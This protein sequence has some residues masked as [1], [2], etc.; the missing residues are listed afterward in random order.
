MALHHLLIDGRTIQDRFPGIARYVYNLAEALAPL[1]AGEITLLTNPDLPNSRYDLN[2]LA[3]HAN[4]RL[5]PTTIPTFHPREQTDLPRLI[6]SLRPDLAH[7]PYN[8]RPYRPGLPNLLTLFDAI[9]RRFP[10]CYPRR[11]RWTIAIVQR[12]AIRSADA[13]VAISAATA[14]DFQHLYRLPAERITLTPLA[15][16]PAFR[17]QPPEQIETVRQRL[18]LPARYV[19]YL[20]SNQ[21][22]KNLPALLAAWS[23]LSAAAPRPLLVIAGAWDPHHPQAL[24]QAERLGGTVRFLPN[25]A[26]ADL[27]GLY[28]GAECFVF[29]SLYEGFGLPVL[30]AMA[31]GTPVV[32]SNASSL[33]EVAGDAALLF[34]PTQPEAIAAAIARLLAEPDLAADLICRG[35]AQAANFSWQ[36]TAAATLSAYQRLL[37]QA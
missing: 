37:G 36:R 33:P 11:T 32:C 25:V 4:L 2:Q 19:L 9:P 18:A 13:F 14:R 10:A 22:H 5:H 12:L 27:P 16:D 17:P 34:D 1:F 28:S 26:A 20:G 23:I 30:E 24:Q 7:L 3:R 8:V 6:R 29:P 15:A 35:L 21:P 31:C